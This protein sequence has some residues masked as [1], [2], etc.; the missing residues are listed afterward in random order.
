VFPCKRRSI[1]IP[2]PLGQERLNRLFLLILREKEIILLL[3]TPHLFPIRPV[4]TPLKN[5]GGL[6]GETHENREKG[7]L[8]A[9]AQGLLSNA[10]FACLSGEGVLF[11]PADQRCTTYAHAAT[12]IRTWPAPSF[13]ICMFSR[14]FPVSSRKQ[15]AIT[16]KPAARGGGLPGA[17]G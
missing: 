12:T 7:V 5:P 17:L 4:Y 15:T 11:G 2:Q 1:E 13:C 8:V 16:A 10:F 6:W 9:A 14:D 3:N